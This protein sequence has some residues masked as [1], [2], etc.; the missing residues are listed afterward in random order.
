MGKD[1]EGTLAALKAHRKDLL[2]PKAAQYH[3]RTVKL[4]GDGALMEFGSVVDA[5]L[6]AIEVQ[7]AMR[8]RNAGVPEDRQIIYRVGINI[9]DIIVEGDDI[10]GDG[11]NVAARL[12]GLAEPGGVRVSQTVFNHIKGKVDLDF[13]DLGEQEVKNIAEPVR[14][15]R[16]VLDDKAAAFVTPVVLPRTPPNRRTWSVAI[17]ALFVALLIL[18]GVLWWQPRTPDFEPASLERMVL[19]IPDK[20]SLAVLPFDNMSG[21]PEQ[22]YFV[23]GMTEDLIT[24]LS[25]VS[26]IFVIARNSSFTYKGKPTKVQEV[27]ED[28]GVRYVLEG[29]VRRI[30]DEVR[31]NAQL[32]DAIGGNHLWAE[33]YDGSMADV[34]ALQDSV[35]RQIVAALAVTLSSDEKARALGS[36]TEVPEAY[37]AFLQGWENYRLGVYEGFTT[38]AAHFEEAI[39]L[40]P[41]FGRAYAALAATHWKQINVNWDYYAGKQWQHLRERGM[42]ML[43]KALEFSNPLGYAV[44]A[45][46]NALEGRHEQALAAIDRAIALAP[47]D[48]ES[49]LSK[50]LVLNVLG[51]AEEAEDAVRTA[52]RLNPHFR[53]DYLRIL[54]QSLFNQ[55]RYEEAADVAERVVKR[56]QEFGD[57]YLALAAIYGHLG[58]LD[59]AA[60]A[61]ANY[62]EAYIAIGYTT[63]MSVQ[64]A[65]YWWYGD[66]YSYHAAY[67]EHLQEGLRKAGVREGVGTDLAYDEYR[68]LISKDNGVYSVEGATRIDAATAKSLHE[69]GVVF[70]DVR[71]SGNFGIGH[72]P[73]AHNL[74]LNAALNEENLSRLVAKD[75]EVVLNCFGEHCPYAAYASAKAV[76]WGFTQVYYFA[77]GFPEWKDAGY[78]VE[79]AP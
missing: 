75:E 52:M 18:V 66:M 61:A 41:S 5:V 50:A 76:L 71:D 55:K 20:P 14:V 40:D 16:A 27:A 49:F 7:S 65:G 17:S 78:P 45:E 34:F 48:A 26:G 53:P 38:A 54:A 79:T 67:R 59:A 22:E 13:E 44:S 36:E 62:N 15:Y 2:E 10:Y 6:F 58:R 28:L 56:R 3:G 73:A 57:D 63:P 12:E 46:V 77:G 43:A 32:V 11:V 64:E 1:E 29:S 19:P 31:I 33:R 60:A 9:G 70:V 21:D 51:R 69:R 72:V 25:K 68:S 37:D 42:A 47:G 39:E 23:D 30:G 4:M 74:D 24:D 35:I 8:G